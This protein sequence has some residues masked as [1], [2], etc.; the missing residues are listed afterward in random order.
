LRPACKTR[1]IRTIFS[2]ILF[3]ASL[4]SAGATPTIDSKT[5]KIDSVE[6]HYVAAGRGPMVLLLHGFAETSRMWRPII[7]SLAEKFAVIAPDLP[8]IG[9]SSSDVSV[10]DAPKDRPLDS[11]RK[12]KRNL[13]CL[14]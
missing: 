13:G 9:D 11:G 2:F 8:G 7:P 4:Q 3:V 5:A 6:L 10:V 14:D 1:L 12:T